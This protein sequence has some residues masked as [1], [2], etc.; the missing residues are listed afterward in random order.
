[1]NSGDFAIAIDLTEDER[2][3]MA[4]ALG[5]WGGS[6][7]Y[8]PLPVGL[9]GVDSWTAFDAL[10]EHLREAI[11]NAKPLPAI[12]WARALFLSELSFASDIVGAGVEFSTVSRFTDEEAIALL[13]SLQRKIIVVDP[14]GRL[15]PG[16]GRRLPGN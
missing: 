5:E 16:Q 14:G 2:D 1:V 12:D 6:A 4:T 13:R 7:S 10:T 3:F 11:K 15:F 9:V 8:A